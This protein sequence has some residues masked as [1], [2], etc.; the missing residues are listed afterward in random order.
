VPP[1]T[2]AGAATNSPGPA[3]PG[4]AGPGR[5]RPPPGRA[6][7]A[8]SPHRAGG[9]ATAP[10]GT[11]GSRPPWAGSRWSP[12]ATARPEGRRS[13]T[14]V[15]LGAER[16]GEV[17]AD[18]DELVGA[19]GR[20]ELGVLEVLGSDPEHHVAARRHPPPSPRPAGQD[21]LRDGQPVGTEGGE[22]PPVR[23]REP[24]G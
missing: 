17:D 18:L 16:F 21:R 4:T 22:H 11:T 10:R 6:W 12:A 14:G 7:S 5:T 8:P 19:G 13:A 23:R 24:G 3:P 9:G 1:T 2:A 15:P 20:G